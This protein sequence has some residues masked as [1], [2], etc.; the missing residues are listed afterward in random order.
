MSVLARH[1]CGG[2]KK[3]SF[4]LGLGLELVGIELGSGSGLESGG[5]SGLGLGFRV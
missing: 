3:Y 4:D 2:H 5:R 1:S